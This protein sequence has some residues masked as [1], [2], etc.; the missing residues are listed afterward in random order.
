MGLPPSARVHDETSGCSRYLFRHRRALRLVLG[1]VAAWGRS[2]G[3]HSSRTSG[4]ERGGSLRDFNLE[5]RLFEYPL[6]FLIYSDSFD[7]LPEV[8][9]RRVYAR[10]RAVLSGTDETGDFEHIDAA[11]REAIRQILS[12]TKPDFLN[13]PS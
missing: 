3:C 2:A 4:A 1:I 6:S 5:T 12:E 7:A 8:V 11:H 10:I 13:A 9:M